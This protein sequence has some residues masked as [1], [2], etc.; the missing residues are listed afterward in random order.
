MYYFSRLLFFSSTL[1]FADNLSSSL[2]LQGFTGLINTPNAQVISEGNAIL[3]YNN[4]FDN[5][6][7]YY[8]YTHSNNREDDYVLG[9]G[10]LPSFELSARLVEAKGYARDLSGNIKY[11]LPYSHSYLPNL[12]LGVQDL[13]GEYSFY[14]NYYV[15]MDKEIGIFRPSLG[16]G[17]SSND[18]VKGKRMDG[19]FG[20]VEAQVTNWLSVMAEYDGKENHTA[21]RLKAP[22]DWISSFNLET[23][24]VQNL[25]HSETSFAIN[26][27]IPLS[28]N[29]QKDI[30]HTQKINNSVSTSLTSKREETSLQKDILP[31]KISN[32][33]LN[34]IQKR[35]IKIGFENVQLGTYDKSIY[36]KA[37]NSI[38]DHTDLDALGV[39]MG[40]IVQEANIYNH[41]TITLLK[42]NIQ[43]L[44]VSGDTKST[45]KYFE[46]PTIENKQNFKNSLI[47]SRSFNE[48]KVQFITTKQN[49]SFFVP[50]LELSPGLT[51]TVG[52]E[53]GVF[54]YLVALRANVYTTLYDGLTLSAMYEMPFVNSK[55]FD[56]GYT[57]GVM[58][59]DK[60]DNRLVNAMLHQTFHYKDLIN[61][62]SIGEFQSDYYG[63]LNH[64]NFTT[65]SGEDGFN[66]KIG[67]FKNKNDKSDE[68]RNI[69][70]GSYRY[71]YA[72]L[73][74]FAEIGYG[75]YWEQDKGAI[76]S[77][78]RFFGET[79]VSLYLKDSVKTY[80][81]FTVTVPFT[82][83]KS[84]NSKWG[85]VK[86]KKDFN[87]GIRTVVK[88]PDHANY[89]NPGGAIIPK[90]DLELTTHYLDRDRLNG[91]Y[92][93]KHI[94]RMREA[95]LIYGRNF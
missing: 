37:E 82:T 83:R 69:Y 21:I 57:Y 10:F 50:R 44:A 26:V 73:D 45:K 64:T 62:T 31:T 29:I 95:Y 47:F 23:T 46:N 92:I 40:T 89:L 78:K 63:F 15:V 4:Q 9:I 18:L 88:S 81:G 91:S 43:T 51:T 66:L 32:S 77:F 80:A 72:P 61:T 76:L 60:L 38:F 16:Y 7:R 39:I 34:R 49:S 67:S 71:F 11:K 41:Y 25:T 13:G 53:V 30:K 36:I 90:T 33:A 84:Y 24:L 8:D 56:K 79:E 74:L 75:Q 12:A 14:T 87:Y 6:L 28:H 52:T 86:G 3:H 35:L 68:T 2:S 58:Y 5:H 20:G 93:K 65:T 17:K 19:L 22:K 85:Q 70:I 54:D 27:S 55:N 42:N 1:L 94:D 59:Q 48:E